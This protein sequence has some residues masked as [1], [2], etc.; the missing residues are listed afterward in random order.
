[1]NRMSTIGHV[2]F[3]LDGT[4]VDSQPGIARSVGAAL[5]ACGVAVQAPDLKRLIGPPVRDILAAASGLSGNAT[6]DRLE[7]AFRTS[8]DTSGWRLTTCQPGVVEMLRRLRTQAVTLFMATNK[9]SRAARRILRGLA[10]EPLFAEVVSPDSQFPVFASKAEMLIDLLERHRI[11]SDGCLMIGDTLE[12]CHAAAAAG[13]QCLVVQ[14]GYWTGGDPPAG[15]RMIRGW[16]E[17]ESLCGAPVFQ[18]P[19]AEKLLQ[20]QY[21]RP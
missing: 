14:H 4:L 6:L 12:D 18:K 11:P 20:E 7:S 1:M 13:L 19:R 5:T 10:L 15:C 21:D 16:N 2:I 3:D 9:P 17:L 8:Y